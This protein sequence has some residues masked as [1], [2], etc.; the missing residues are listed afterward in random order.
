[1]STTIRV[2]VDVK[3]R[4]EELKEELKLHSYSEVIEHLLEKISDPKA[5]LDSLYY[6]IMD[7][8]R[9]VKRLAE[10]LE[11]LTAEIEKLQRAV[12]R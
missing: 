8:R 5:V 9:D 3:R 12:S 1:M 7:V 6:W 11:K 10:L 2:G 4:L